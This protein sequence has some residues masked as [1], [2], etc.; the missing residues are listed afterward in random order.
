MSFLLHW[1][2]VEEGIR[3]TGQMDYRKVTDWIE[4]KW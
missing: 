1:S 4:L 2:T 3:M